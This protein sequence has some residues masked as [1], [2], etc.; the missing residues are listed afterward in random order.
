MLKIAVVVGSTRPGRRC[1]AVA[2]WVADTLAH[3][4]STEP[5][6]SVSLHLVDLAELE[7]PLLNEPLPP[8]FGNYE[9]AWT[10][11]WADTVGAFDAFVFVTPEYNHSLPA[12]LKNAI[13]VVWAEWNDK[14]AG[15][16]SYGVHGG[17]RAVEHLR[18]VLAEV[19]VAGVRSQVVLSM[20]EDFAITD[21]T[22]PGEFTPRAH[23]AAI[24]AEMFDEL[25]AWAVALK[26]LRHSTTVPVPA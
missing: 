8:I 16:V 12:V 24:L 5:G 11:E 25:V 10:Q 21:P 7:L 23:Q 14:A 9:S 6:G 1:R 17:T 26:T 18:Q 20:Y 2:D 19:K 22:E 4:P 3:H 15:F 13:D